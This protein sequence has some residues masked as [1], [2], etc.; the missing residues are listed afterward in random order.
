MD[1]KVGVV[2]GRIAIKR[3]KTREILVYTY[4]IIYIYIYTY[5]LYIY[6][7]YIYIY[8]YIYIYRDKILKH[9]RAKIAL[10]LGL[11]DRK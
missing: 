2:S 9:K 7:L 11:T 3:M 1:G 4:K 8:I 10:V 5:I 6:I